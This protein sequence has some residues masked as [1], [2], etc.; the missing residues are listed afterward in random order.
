MSQSTQ[1][2]RLTRIISAYSRVVRKVLFFR[3]R[4]VDAVITLGTF[5]VPEQSASLP[6]RRR[7]G[8][9]AID[10]LSVASSVVWCLFSQSAI[11]LQLLAQT[12]VQQVNAMPHLHSGSYDPCLHFSAIAM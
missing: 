7:E 8:S 2:S 5:T 11:V 6:D 1:I 3:H 4:N 10:E 9:Y 12:T